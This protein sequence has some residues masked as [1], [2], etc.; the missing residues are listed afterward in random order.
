MQETVEFLELIEKYGV[1][2]RAQ[3]SGLREFVQKISAWINRSSNSLQSNGY[4]V[5]IRAWSGREALVVFES[6]IDLTNETLDIYEQHYRHIVKFTEKNETT[7]Y[8]D[9][10][11][12]EESTNFKTKRIKN[13]ITRL[14]STCKIVLERLFIV[15]RF[16][17]KKNS[18]NIECYR[19]VIERSRHQKS[20]KFELTMKLW[21]L[22]AHVAFQSFA[23]QCHS[24]I[25][26][27]GTLSPLAPFEREL[28][29]NFPIRVEAQH[30]IDTAS[31]VYVSAVSTFD[32]TLMTSTY[33]NQSNLTYLDS[34]GRCILTLTRVTTGGVLV[35]FSSYSFLDKI[36]ERWFTTQFLDEFD[37]PATYTETYR[38]TRI[39]Y[40]PKEGD[41]LDGVLGD[42]YESI[43]QGK[44][45]LF[46][47]VCRGKVSEGIDF[48]D[49]YAR[50][51][52]VIGIPFPNLSSL[53]IKMKR[54]YLDE[55]VSKYPEMGY[56]T[57]DQWYEQQAFRAVNQAF[58]RCIRHVQDFGAIIL[59][60]P[61]YQKN[62]NQQQLSRWVRSNVM[63]SHRL[64]D[65][66]LPM[67][68][69]FQSNYERFADHLRGLEEKIQKRKPIASAS[70]S[71]SSSSKKKRKKKLKKIDLEFDEEVGEQ[72]QQGRGQQT[73]SQIYSKY[74]QSLPPVPSPV[75]S[76]PL[77][78]AP[79][80]SREKKSSANIPWDGRRQLVDCL[81]QWE[82]QPPPCEDED[83]E[84]VEL[85][86]VDTPLL[87]QELPSQLQYLITH[88]VTP[89]EEV[90]KP[91]SHALSISNWTWPVLS[92]PLPC[93]CSD[94]GV[95]SLQSCSLC[96]CQLRVVEEWNPS[97]R[98]VYRLLLCPRLNNQIPPVLLA[99]KVIAATESDNPLLNKSFVNWQL[100]QEIFSDSNHLET[101]HDESFVTCEEDDTS[102]SI[103]NESSQS[104]NLR[105]FDLSSY[106]DDEFEDDAMRNPSRGDCSG[107]SDGEN[108]FEAEESSQKKVRTKLP[109][110]GHSRRKGK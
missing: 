55:L 85:N 36:K 106:R 17:M 13:L 109:T 23:E 73:L 32:N 84:F 96:L 58:G 12:L 97:D 57:G 35:F 29:V 42:Y 6:E 37:D 87:L 9:M 69:F 20:Y 31:Q 79:S 2:C 86:H 62:Q 66:L 61:R 65:I 27:S 88:L 18:S 50:T 53:Q 19:V 56:L 1:G 108:D 28:G 102:I 45:C 34:V 103:M 94:S 16:M 100:A 81:L 21:C 10:V 104:T 64:E 46:L 77:S 3:A 25:L 60:D 15:L 82:W 83:S 39:F 8:P 40:E 5:E 63:N 48:S 26:T 110:H 24:I 95:S 74:V 99:A 93:A 89:S 78:P 72:Q 49:N 4:E 54:T 91:P 11:F 30:V 105:P 76:P 98:V 75:P 68:I 51:V 90:L 67:R 41:K 59:C 107:S 70:Q 71:S 92:P 33:L 38:G 22:S 47:A 80:P 101:L 14:F 43:D 52:I 7:E 44:Q